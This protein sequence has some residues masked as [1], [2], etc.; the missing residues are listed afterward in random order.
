M[1][2]IM[3]IADWTISMTSATILAEAAAHPF[4]HA[5]ALQPVGEGVYEGVPSPRY[6]NMAGPFGGIT[7]ATL[8]KGVLDHPALR[9]RPLAQ[10]V[11]FCAAI[12]PD[13]FVLKVVLERDGKSTQ[14]WSVRLEQAGQMAA[15]A[16]RV[17]GPER[18]TWAHQPAQPPDVGEASSVPVFDTAAATAWFAQYEM[19]FEHGAFGQEQ[20]SQTG[21]TR[22]WLRDRQPRALD[23]LAL[24]SM[25]DAFAPRVFLMRGVRAPA[26]TVSL[27]TYFLAGQTEL[28]AQ[29]A[30]PILG[31]AQPRAASQGFHDQ[32]VELWSDAKSLLAVSHQL[33]WFKD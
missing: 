13:P 22:A 27:S 25:A 18:E 12:T 10:T 32:T 26:A 9:G 2:T 15:N 28:S 5:L 8:L 19:R 11:N 23:Y 20:P 16:T 30:R 6:W 1:L 21:L 14:H 17:T 33:V 31:S 29:A 7:A 24:A 4:D 3:H